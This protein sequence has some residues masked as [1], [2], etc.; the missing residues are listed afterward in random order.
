M[1]FIRY[2]CTVRSYVL[3][4]QVSEI[5][6]DDTLVLGS[7]FENMLENVKLSTCDKA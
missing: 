6:D 2:C 5:F 1:I 4:G 3:T 7:P